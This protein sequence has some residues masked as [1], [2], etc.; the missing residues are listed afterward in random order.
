MT[1]SRIQLAKFLWKRRKQLW[2][3][4]KIEV[5]DIYTGAKEDF[6]IQSNIS[7]V[8]KIPL[9]FFR[10]LIGISGSERAIKYGYKTPAT[11][12]V[13]IIPGSF[14]DQYF[15]RDCLDK[16][17]RP[18]SIDCTVAAL[19]TRPPEVI[20]KIF[21]E[22]TFRRNHYCS[23]ALADFAVDENAYI[24]LVQWQHNNILERITPKYD[25]EFLCWVGLLFDQSHLFNTYYP[26]SDHDHLADM[27]E[28]K[29]YSNHHH[30]IMFNE[31]K[32]EHALGLLRERQREKIMA[33]VEHTG[34]TK[35]R[36]M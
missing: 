7:A 26:L 5:K 27:I 28:H 33:C 8:Y 17:Q 3:K 29:F 31:D 2:K 15:F 36:K 23:N 1:L 30:C 6:D 24:Y 13:K 22:V 16:F 12:F 11:F 9:M 35:K 20:N 19:L 14:S 32:K 34:N 4:T 21:Q 18:K 10:L 25:P